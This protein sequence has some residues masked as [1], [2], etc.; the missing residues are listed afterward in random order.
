MECV[1]F[2]DIEKHRD[3][4]LNAFNDMKRDPNFKNKKIRLVVELAYD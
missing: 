3:I 1:D 4:I 2:D